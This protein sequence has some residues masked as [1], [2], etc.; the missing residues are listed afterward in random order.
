MLNMNT[1]G[2]L[3]VV[4]GVSCEWVLE[5]CDGGKRRVVQDELV[6]RNRGALRVVAVHVHEAHRLE[7]GLPVVRVVLLV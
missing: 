7:D 5:C 6:V 3:C 2:E 1:L 4:Q